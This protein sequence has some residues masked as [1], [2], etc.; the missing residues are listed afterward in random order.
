MFI[1]ATSCTYITPVPDKAAHSP[2]SGLA[3]DFI[4]PFVVFSTVRKISL[5]LSWKLLGEILPLSI[6]FTTISLVVLS[7]CSSIVAMLPLP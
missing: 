1:L 7:I 4:E 2:L 3:V 5:K 6:N